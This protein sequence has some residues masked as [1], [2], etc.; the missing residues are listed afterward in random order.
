M[1]AVETRVDDGLA[2]AFDLPEL[3]RLAGDG[4]QVYQEG[5]PHDIA[6]ALNELAS[7]VQQ[8]DLG[9]LR[10]TVDW[11]MNTS[12][13]NADMAKSTM[14]VREV[15]VL[16]RGMSTAVSQITSSVG[17]V[18]SSADD[19]AKTLQRCLVQAEKGQAA[20]NR[21]SDC[22]DSISRNME[23]ASKSISDFV[24]ASDQIGSIVDA[25]SQIA[26]MTDL[27]ALNASVEATRA[28]DAGRGFGVVA[29]EIKRLATQTAEATD[30]IRERI[31]GLQNGVRGILNS[32][33][34][35]T[36]SVEQGRVACRDAETSADATKNE[37]AIGN[38]AVAL[39]ARNLN[40]QRAAVQALG[41]G[42]ARVADTAALAEARI[43]DMMSSLSQMEELI[44]DQFAV[45]DQADIPDYVLYRAK[46]DHFL[47][48]K[49]LAGMAAGLNNLKPEELSDHTMCRLGKWYESVKDRDILRNAAFAALLRPH[50]AVHTHGKT[51]ARKFQEG[52]RNGAEAAIAEMELASEKVV[53]LLN[54]LISRS[55][56]VRAA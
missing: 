14:T 39:I 52:D 54:M 17:V 8:R 30:E 34:E 1:S 21:T 4:R 36:D 16:A 28:G 9:A 3:I 5:L 27:L 44:S 24:R 29:N 12:N 45:L 19:A 46:S 55:R 18:S 53:E 33:K 26:S 32:V 2:W 51:A 31:A 56:G 50:A 10:R 40:E 41:G 38:E 23:S 37:I 6:K 7:R 15:D 20:T 47:W 25:I 11:S 42:V 13:A 43:T 35:S 48:K 22:M 49:N